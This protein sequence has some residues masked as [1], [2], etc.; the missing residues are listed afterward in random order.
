[1]VRISLNVLEH[2][3]LEVDGLESDEISF[4]KRQKKEGKIKKI[5]VQGK[6]CIIKANQYVGVIFLKNYKIH[7]EPKVPLEN[8]FKIIQ[9]A[10][11]IPS[12][13]P[14]EGLLSSGDSIQDLIIN[15]FLQLTHKMV[16]SGVKREYQEKSET[17]GF[18]RGKI[19]FQETII[20][21]QGK[22]NQLICL[23]DDY[24][25]NIIENQILKTTFWYIQKTN[26]NN[27]QRLSALQLMDI[28]HEVSLI[29]DLDNEIFNTIIYNQLNEMYRVLHYLCKFILQN[30]SYHHSYGDIPFS[31]FLI[32]MNDLFEEFIF[33]L[34]KKY[35][36]NNYT[37]IHEQITS[38][39]TETI[40]GENT[41]KSIV[42][43]P[44][45]SIY[46]NNTIKAVLDAKYKK[47]PF[48]IRYKKPRVHS[49]NFYQIYSYS[50]IKSCPGALI[51]PQNEEKVLL[52]INAGEFPI[53]IITIDLNKKKSCF[54]KE[55]INF[56]KLVKDLL[57][58]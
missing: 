55:C 35:D 10:K 57:I 24:T 39:K 31:S 14:E 46:K 6:K 41:P 21:Y 3:K 11:R 29:P 42:I 38:K 27:Q 25:L 18:I 4:L 54:K 32:D 26:P 33:E 51:Y 34:L 45:I 12:L 40:V 9:I 16:L 17:S 36:I 37:I 44:D 7:I 53:T 5:E 13:L 22:L 8:L 49:D 15:Y 58:I 48:V 23:H 43:K 20:K 28:F 19:L 52:Q 47:N 1:M 30:L 2:K 56:C 50:K